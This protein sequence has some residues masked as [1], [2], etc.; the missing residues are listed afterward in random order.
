[1]GVVLWGLVG[2]GI[3][4]F[5]LYALYVPLIAII[6][7]RLTGFRWSPANVRLGMTIAPVTLLAFISQWV[8]TGEMAMMVGF[9]L[10][11]LLSVY[12]LIMLRSIF[13][14]EALIKLSRA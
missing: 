12:S 14:W 6:V 5:L 13:G 11:T 9:A 7:R 3:A 4:Y 2:A 8:F 1:M 10:T